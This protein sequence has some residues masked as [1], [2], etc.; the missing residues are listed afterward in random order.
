MPIARM[1]TAPMRAVIPILAALA[2][3]CGASFGEVTGKVTY[4]SLPLTSGNVMFLASDGRPYDGTI[5]AA[6][7]YAI[8]KLPIGLAK[9]AV[10]C[11]TPVAKAGS[12]EVKKTESRVSPPDETNV[13]SAI[14]LRYG[15][16]AGSKLVVAIESGRTTHDIEL[17]D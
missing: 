1:S 12:R 8:R 6:G 4:K 13:L 7:N 3:G 14:P 11:L 10:T 9:I 17:G 16:F 15:D 5:D 2:G